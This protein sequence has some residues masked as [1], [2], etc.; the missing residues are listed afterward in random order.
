MLVD[1]FEILNILFH[2]KTN[3]KSLYSIIEWSHKYYQLSHLL[4]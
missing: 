3:K 4:L 2:Q 1:S